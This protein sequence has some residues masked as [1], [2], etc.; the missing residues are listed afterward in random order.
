VADALH[1]FDQHAALAQPMRQAGWR[2]QVQTTP[3]AAPVEPRCPQAEGV[4]SAD[5]QRAAGRQQADGFV[6]TR[7]PRRHA[8]AAADRM[9]HRRRA[10]THRRA[11]P[12]RRA[13]M[14]RSA[15]A[16]PSGLAE[17]VPVRGQAWR[18]KAAT[19]VRPRSAAA[20]ASS[21]RSVR[22]ARP[23]AA[24]WRGYRCHAGTCIEQPVIMLNRSVI[25]DGCICGS[26][27]TAPRCV[28]E[29]KWS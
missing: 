11:P 21:R 23:G 29:A 12:D 26:R 14:V 28:A 6:A 25:V 19:H 17:A 8:A 15:P 4:Q 22:Q 13:K 24:R 5:D 18:R 20:S 3:T 27:E 16:E 7:R 1:L 10:G 2:E 9:H